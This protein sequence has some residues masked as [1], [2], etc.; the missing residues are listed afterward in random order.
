MKNTATRPDDTL[1]VSQE[2]FEIATAAKRLAERTMALAERA[3]SEAADTGNLE[4]VT[5]AELAL[6]AATSAIT[7]ASDARAAWMA[8]VKF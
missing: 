1:T 6:S 5:A 7:A 4:Q 2:L 8:S 3:L